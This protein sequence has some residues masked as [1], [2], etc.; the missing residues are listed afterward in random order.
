MLWNDPHIFRSNFYAIRKSLYNL[1][2]LFLSFFLLPHKEQKIFLGKTWFTIIIIACVK[3][4]NGERMKYKYYEV[5]SD[6]SVESTGSTMCAGGTLSYCE[7][8]PI[9][10]CVSLQFVL[11]GFCRQSIFVTCL[12]GSET[13]SPSFLLFLK[14]IRW[15]FRCS[16]SRLRL[17]NVF[18]KVFGLKH[19]FFAVIRKVLTHFRRTWVRCP[20][21]VRSPSTYPWEI[22]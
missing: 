13:I 6:N 20:A 8:V 11:V 4:W 10:R 1:W 9:G 22:V 18:E 5:S 2:L 14:I 3:N 17:K 15:F 12:H 7:L 16:N 19:F 21:G